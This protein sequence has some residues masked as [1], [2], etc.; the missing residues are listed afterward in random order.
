MSW[1][2]NNFGSCPSAQ[3]TCKRVDLMPRP[4]RGSCLARLGYCLGDNFELA[5]GL[6]AEQ[7]RDAGADHHHHGD[8][9]EGYRAD[10]VYGSK[11]YGTSTPAKMRPVASPI[12]LPPSAQRGRELGGWVDERVCPT[13]LRDPPL[14]LCHGQAFAH[15]HGP[16]SARVMPWDHHE[17]RSSSAQTSDSSATI[18]GAT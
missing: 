5:D 11:R 1:H 10:P 2:R 13:G 8:R 7:Q 3:Q 9:P 15:L 18:G 14:R 16:A 17:C 4:I 6:L 12:K